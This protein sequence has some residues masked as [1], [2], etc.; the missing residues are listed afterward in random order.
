[1]SSARRVEAEGAGGEKEAD[2][3]SVNVAVYAKARTEI[4]ALFRWDAS[5]LSP[6]QMLRLDCAVA[7]RLALDDLQV[8]RVAG[9]GRGENSVVAVSLKKKSGEGRGGG[10]IV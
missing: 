6:D 5:S 2:V 8:G 3:L 1:M 7:L 10:S 4:I 9:G